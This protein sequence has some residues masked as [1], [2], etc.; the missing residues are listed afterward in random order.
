[1]Y[2]DFMT[3]NIMIYKNTPY[4]IDY[5]GGRRGPL[6]YDLASILFQAKANLPDNFRQKMLD[7]YIDSLGEYMNVDR[8]SFVQYYYSFVWIR[9]LQVLGAYGFRGYFEKKAHFIESIDFA[10]KNVRWLL[11]NV[12]LPISMPE[13]MKCMEEISIQDEVANLKSSKTLSVEINSF[14]F[15]YMGIPEDETEHGGGFVF[16]CRA[17]HNPGRYPEYRQLTGRDQPVIEFLQ[18]EPEVDKFLQSVYEIADQAIEKYIERDFDH[19]MINFGCT[20]GQHRS[21]YCAENL[22]RHVKEKYDLKVQ[23]K[24]LMQE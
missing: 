15:I 5:Q 17:L 12:Q 22:F 11:K 20:G 3:R 1:M 24:H 2:R 8:E 19:L 16:D 18:K 9:T 10:I 4:F 14:S 6:Q 21:V 13:L 7:Y 23:L